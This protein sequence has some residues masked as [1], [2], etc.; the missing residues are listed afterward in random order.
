MK[1]LAL[2]PDTKDLIITGL[3]LATVEGSDYVRQSL[4]IRLGFFQGEWFL[5]TTAGTPYY[6]DIFLKNPDLPNIEN[7]FK[8][9]IIETN[10]VN[11]L[12]EFDLQLDSAKRE[13][14]LFAKVNTDFGL[15]EF[16]ET[17]FG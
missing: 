17:I 6:Q 10:F 9:R 3:D 13:A 5:D 1:D 14:S 4:S 7:I 12:T 15:V 16:S 8:A 2:D 11:E